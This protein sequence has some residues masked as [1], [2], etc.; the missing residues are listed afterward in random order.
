MK[1]CVLV[2]MLVLGLLLILSSE[3]YGADRTEYVI[4]LDNHGSASWTIRQTGTDIQVSPETLAQFQNNVTSLMLAAQSRTQRN[5]AITALSVTSTVSG[6]YAAVEYKF[7]W[8]NFSRTENASMTVGDVFQVD[9]FFALL[10]GD[11]E[12]AMTYPEGYDLETVSPPPIQQD[13]AHQTLKWAGTKD[14]GNGLPAI[15][16]RQ[17]LPGF[18]DI[19]GQNV[20]I[21]T[22]LLVIA[23]VSSTS[24]YTIIRRRKKTKLP[25]PHE[26]PVL[27]QIETDEERVVKLL[28][29]SGGSLFQSA[30]TEKCNFSKAKASQLLSALENRGIV[31]RHKR[32]RDK[33]VVLTQEDRK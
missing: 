31:R 32:G 30:V 28:R 20:L 7:N 9:N 1:T 8:E 15:A 3:V 10:Y 29:S 2:F 18:L 11:G 12:V 22:S 27:A 13:D 26:V 17:K 21:V 6:S 25:V 5:M 4:Q 24:Y 33:I 16:L 23:A 14:F 19:L